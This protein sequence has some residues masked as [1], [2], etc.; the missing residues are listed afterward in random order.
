[1][2][3]AFRQNK[4]YEE[5]ILNN[6]KQISIRQDKKKRWK[7]GMKIHLAT[8]VR[9]KEYN[10]FKNSFVKN[11]DEIEINN[12]KVYLNGKMLNKQEIEDIAYLDGY[13]NLE[14]FFKFFGDNYKGRIIWW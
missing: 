7:K 12:K 6:K 8:G 14:D 9:T 2:I 3:L 13:D 1:M 5:A 10:C 4:G 11:V